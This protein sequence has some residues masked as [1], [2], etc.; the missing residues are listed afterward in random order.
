MQEL[1][2]DVLPYLAAF[3]AIELA[4]ILRRH[5]LLFTSGGR[6]FRLRTAGLGALPPWPGTEVIA[7]HALPLFYDKGGLWYADPLRPYAP[8][9]L[10]PDDL[11]ALAF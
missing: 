8:K 9:V 1:L 6:R 3:Y 10:A 5:H 11:T 2:A 7:S 4:V